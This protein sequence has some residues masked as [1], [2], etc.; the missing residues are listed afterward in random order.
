MP[1]ETFT[2]PANVY[3]YYDSRIRPLAPIVYD[4]WQRG[5]RIDTE[6]LN[7]V[8]DNYTKLRDEHQAIVNEL[9]GGPI[10]VKSPIDMTRVF[11]KLGVKYKPTNSKVVLNKLGEL[12]DVLDSDTDDEA[13]GVRKSVYRASTRESDMLLYAQR[14]I[15]RPDVQKFILECLEVVGNRTV[16]SGFLDPALDVN[17]YYHPLLIPNLA[18]TGRF[19]GKGSLEG[20]PQPQNWPKPIRT[21]VI[22]DSPDH[23]LTQADLK[24][25]EAMYVAWDACD[26][27]MMAAFQQQKDA[28][29]VAGCVLF[30][31]WKS[32]QLPSDELMASVTQLCPECIQFNIEQTARGKHGI[33]EC[34]H[35]ERYYSK[36]IGHASRYKMGPRKLVQ[37]VLPKAGIYITEGRGKL[38]QSRI[39]GPAIQA[40]WKR[41]KAQLTKS[42]VLYNA[43]YRYREFYG[44]LDGRNG[45]AL[46]R[47]ALAW[48]AQSTVGDITNRAMCWLYPRLPKSAR[49]L[50]QTHDSLLVC[51]L[52]SERQR[53]RD[54]MTEAFRHVLK[55]KDH[56]GER[57]LSIPID[58]A[59][60]DDWGSLKEVK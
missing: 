30:H 14:E 17:N 25:A 50:T 41:V 37:E 7:K 2:K 52:R 5:M 34:Q 8:R 19:G 26:P 40:W 56:L 51:A 4:M 45:E 27:L 11:R 1:L 38:F 28:H 39:C 31:D 23:E 36:Q 53:I 6:Q 58:L 12:D 18:V 32:S 21:I 44:S 10:N 57:Y 55:F 15:K 20:G 3:E 24:Q 47:D 49:L 35:S 43:A 48:L 22:A 42:P 46:L 13:D 54:L 29:R 60:G 16:L 9:A 59:H 33:K